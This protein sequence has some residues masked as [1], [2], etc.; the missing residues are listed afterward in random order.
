MRNLFF[1]LFNNYKILIILNLIIIINN[2]YSQT[3][4]KIEKNI[5]DFT[6]VDITG[7]NKSLSDYKGKVILIVNT[8]S[9]CGFT[10]Q[11]EGLEVLYKKYKNQGFEILG[12]PSNQFAN[13]DP[14]TNKEIFE[15]CTVN[16]GVTFQMFGKI[17]VNGSNAH[18][19]Y[20]YLVNLKDKNLRGKIKWNFTK[21]LI[22]KNGEIIKRYAPQV[23]PSKI[24]ND[25]I[26]LIK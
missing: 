11:F 18:P 16:Y 23:E 12:F 25:I 14:G 3:D 21:F 5:Y 4:L 19:L 20:K 1:H 24:E 2:I 13:Q 22:N 10:P 8:A 15:F 9:N 17:D 6:A 7:K 26:L